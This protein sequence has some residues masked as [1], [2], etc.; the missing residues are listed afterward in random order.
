MNKVA[1]KQISGAVYYLPDNLPR[2]PESTLM[3]FVISDNAGSEGYCCIVEDDA[4]GDSKN[5]LFREERGFARQLTECISMGD[6]QFIYN[7]QKYIVLAYDEGPRTFLRKQRRQQEELE[8]RRLAEELAE[9]ERREKQ[10]ILDYLGIIRGVKSIFHFTPFENLSGIAE[11]GIVPRNQLPDE[12]SVFCPDSIRIDGHRDYSCF[13][14]SYPNYKMFYSYRIKWPQKPF[15]VLEID[16]SVLNLVELKDM[17]FYE[18][19][20]ACGLYWSIPTEE[21]I[22]LAAVEK[23]FY[24]KGRNSII[25]NS[26]PTNPQAELQLRKVIPQ[27][28]IKKVYLNPKDASSLKVLDFPKEFMNR[29]VLSELYFRP[30]CDY[31]FW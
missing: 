29:V 5:G 25:P 3:I 2:I 15:A 11:Q 19:N 1:I 4:D 28:Y 17:L 8:R 23:M 26:Y 14:I 9:S 24:D 21:Q 18:M 22:G 27:N 12:E 13:S 30:R 16:I 7:N 6:D 10:K 31:M 20:A